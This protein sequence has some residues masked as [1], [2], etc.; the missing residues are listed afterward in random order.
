MRF[1]P[2]LRWAFMGTFLT[3]RIAGGMGGMRHFIE[4]FG[5][6]LE[7]P[8]TRLMDVPDLTDDLIDKIAAQ[9]DDQ[10]GDASIR[11]LERL[12][13]DCL[14]SVMHGLETRNYAAGEVLG[15]YRQRLQ[16]GDW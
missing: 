16:K 14:I 7:L 6:T 4:Q 15:R 1:G 9:S 5:P 3:Y 2:G 13:D 10:A 8:W 11:E 12:R